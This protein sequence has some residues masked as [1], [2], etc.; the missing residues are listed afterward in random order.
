MALKK[1]K[2]VKIDINSLVDKELIAEIQAQGGLSFKNEKFIKTGCG[3]EC[4][5]HIYAFPKY[6]D[7]FWLNPICNIE[8]AIV[9]IDIS[10]EDINE[11][12][13]N[14]NKSMREQNSRYVSS[15]DATDRRDAEQRY[16][17]LDELYNEI[18][19][20]GEIVKLV[21]IR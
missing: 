15:K 12:K 16:Q 7:R 11:V 19:V 8:N 20:L 5:I 18:S 13:K 3:Y 10:T 14:I 17:E 4:C 2:E 1:K 6:L 9:T 21:H